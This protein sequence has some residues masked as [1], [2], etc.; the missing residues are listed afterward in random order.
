MT[1]HLALLA[2]AAALSG[3]FLTYDPE[4]V[5]PAPG[6]GGSCEGAGSL[7]EPQSCTGSTLSHASFCANG[8]CPAQTTASCA[9]Y[10]CGGI[11]CK[12]SCGGDVDCTDG[13]FCLATNCVPKRAAGELCVS[14]NQCA[15]DF[16]SPDATCCDTA[17]TGSCE[18]CNG[19]NT[20]GGAPAGTCATV[21]FGSRP[22]PGHAGCTGDAAGACAGYC[23]GVTTASC[24]Y[25][26][27]ECRGA[28]CAAG[29]QTNPASCS[30]G[31]CPVAVTVPCTPYV[32]G[33]TACKVAC[34][35]SADCVPGSYCDGSGQCVAKL[36]QGAPCTG[37]PADQ[38]ATGVCA[39]GV[40][41]ATAC[42]TECRACNLPG[43][44]GLCSNVPAGQDPNGD[45]TVDSCETT[46]TG[47]GACGTAT[48]GAYC[49]SANCTNAAPDPFGRP[50]GA[51]AN[52]AL[53]SGATQTC[54]A[55][56][57]SVQ[58][59]SLHTC[60][61]GQ[62]NV[63]CLDNSDCVSGTLCVAGKCQTCASS[64]DCHPG[65]PQC[66]VGPLGAVC[67]CPG[68]PSCAD[69]ICNSPGDCMAAGFGSVCAQY[70]DYC[71][72]TPGDG[73][74]NGR[75]PRCGATPTGNCTCGAGVDN[76]CAVG[77]LCTDD[78]TSG[79]CKIAPGFPCT[80]IPADCAS[81]SCGAGGMCSRLPATRPCTR[82]DDCTS[83][84]CDTTWR[85]F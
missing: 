19:V 42:A 14:A 34:A 50:T 69:A 47:S 79:T 63:T 40:C 53:C 24:S 59:C 5:E 64:A 27:V 11:G 23:D 9:P 20:V 25:P 21:L 31:S 51:S 46:C 85:C 38:C 56:S 84:V 66:S 1:K 62:C 30:A 16:C 65:S 41:C 58:Q 74:C 13:N 28:S 78:T 55:P 12:T 8:T 43:T 68:D 73:A 36:T 57:A 52:L 4:A 10:V 81:G 44:V 18:T 17:C 67:D 7:C 45:C 3:C 33:P 72:C 29:T 39:Q 71:Q 32:C 37:S 75:G 82:P 77:Q 80:A 70:W 22:E 76:R 49:N 83:G 54:P 48:G 15:S 35:S 6:G 2:A 26:T 61:G 60:D